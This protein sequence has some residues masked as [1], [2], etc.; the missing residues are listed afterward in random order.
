MSE[1][2]NGGGKEGVWG[3]ECITEGRRDCGGDEGEGRGWAHVYP[4]GPKGV[5]QVEDYEFWEGV[6]VR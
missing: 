1:K 2:G 5:V 4:V 3:R 6:L